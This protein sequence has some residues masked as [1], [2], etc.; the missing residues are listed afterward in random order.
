M[1]P[2]P[3]RVSWSGRVVEGAR[4]IVSTWLPAPCGRCGVVIQ[5]TD[6][7]VVGHIKSRHAYPELTLDVTNWQPEHKTCSDR[8]SG[9]AIVERVRRELGADFPGETAGTRAP[10][11]PV[12]PPGVGG[13]LPS[14][15]ALP[16]TLP[17][18]TGRP[19]EVRFDLEWSPEALAEH[20]WL[21]PFLDVPADASPPLF[22]SRPP[23]DAIGSYG[24]DAIEW[25]E[26]ELN[27]TLR[28]WQRLAITRQLE[29]RH[30]GSLCASE[31]IE[32][33]PRRAGKSVRMRG[34]ALWRMADPLR[35]FGEP[36]LVMHTGSDMAICREIQRGAWR[37]AE[38]NWG[39]D[40][41]TKANGKESIESPE[42]N[43]WLVRSQEGVYGYDVTLGLIDEGW[44]VKPDTVSEGIEPA[45]LERIMPQIILTSTAHRRA[46]SLMRGR[47]ATA[48]AVDDPSTVLIVWAAPAGS[49][50]GDP[51]VWR[52]AS[53]HWSE[54]RRKLI[55]RK[56]EA[57][58]AG[59]SDPQ[60]DDPDPLAGFT[61]QYLNV[62]R[63]TER[64]LDRGDPLVEQDPWD[65]LAVGDLP[66]DAPTAAA[67]ES[68]F[69]QGVA[70]ALAWR[71][72]D[73]VIVR[74]TDHPTREHAAA[75]LRATGYRRRVTIGAD[76]LDDPAFRRLST[77]KGTGS[78]GAAAGRLAALITEQAF[79]HAGDVLTEQVLEARTTAGADGRRLVSKGRGDAIKA[80]VWAI[81][82]ARGA[83][84]T[85][86][87]RFI[88]ANA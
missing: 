75:A 46:T 39:K 5:P 20:E 66:A 82:A 41:V 52:A 84:A 7:W 9:E 23:A 48:L 11:L 73:D 38:T 31:Y 85:R 21:K 32:S 1:R 61:S 29:Y 14:Q 28:W 83:A 70:L 58:L 35:L 71:V 57:A 30:D 12:S 27:L 49:E 68:W 65:A 26:G 56:Y 78:A 4:A 67:I 25:I 64:Q 10:A 13:D 2:D 24:P 17:F 40:A 18:P 72:D 47:I 74:V 80:A 33:A 60:A 16:I 87:T 53:P 63:L 44:N 76:M 45:T 62:W 19:M 6:R 86:I 34:V 69:G 15:P 37:W 77:T 51:A 54:D 22:M 79:L 42:G 81:E 55:E 36:Q 8:S 88:T 3:L 50:P 43:R 59:Q